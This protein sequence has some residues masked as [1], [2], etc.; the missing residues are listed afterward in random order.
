MMD[1]I[2]SFGVGFMFIVFIFGI[3]LILSVI[4]PLCDV[5]SIE[6]KRRWVGGVTYGY[7]CCIFIAVVFYIA[8]KVMELFDTCIMQ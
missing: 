5:I 1:I 3:I 2:C 8:Y 6:F 7:V 4:A